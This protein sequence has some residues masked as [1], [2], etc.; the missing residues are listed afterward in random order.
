[1]D[2]TIARTPYPSDI[3]D[4]EANRGAVPG[5]ESEAV[6]GAREMVKRLGEALADPPDAERRQRAEANIKAARALRHGVVNK[7]AVEKYLKQ[8]YGNGRR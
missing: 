8:A 6:V 2:T 7:M 5:R 1:M 3:S 4:E